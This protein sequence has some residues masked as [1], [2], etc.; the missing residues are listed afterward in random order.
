MASEILNNLRAKYPVY[1][2][3][4]DAELAFRITEKYP[5]YK[6]TDL[7]KDAMPYRAAAFG[8]ISARPSRPAML[9]QETVGA[10]KN[11]FG[12]FDEDES[13]LG[14]VARRASA[15]GTLL[16]MPFRA[17]GQA[18]GTAYEKAVP[19]LPGMSDPREQERQVHALEQSVE[20]APQIASAAR[21]ATALGTK[22][23]QRGAEALTE[24]K[25]KV[26]MTT[27]QAKT[28]LQERPAPVWTEEA[29]APSLPE[30]DPL[31]PGSLLKPVQELPKSTPF[32]PTGEAGKI[33]LGQASF[34]GRTAAGGLLGQEAGDTAIDKI[35][36]GAIG[37]VIGAAANPHLI[38]PALKALRAPAQG[39]GPSEIA[40]AVAKWKAKIGGFTPQDI[41]RGL[42]HAE[43][44]V[45]D[46]FAADDVANMVRKTWNDALDSAFKALKYEPQSSVRVLQSL[47]N[48]T[49]QLNPAEAAVAAEVRRVY[50]QMAQN[51][52]TAIAPK[53]TD[54]FKALRGGQPFR[55]GLE[56]LLG[57][58]RAASKKIAVDGGT[59]PDGTLV[60]SFG[61]RGLKAV[62][63]MKKEG[64]PAEVVAYYTQYLND[65]TKGP[66]VKGQ[67]LLNPLTPQMASRIKAVEFMRTIGLNF[68]SAMSNMLQQ[69]NTFARTSPGAFTSA[70][71]DILRNPGVVDL[72]RKLGVTSEVL[73]KADIDSFA[74]PTA[75]DHMLK[76]G[77][78]RTGFLFAKVEEFNRLH[79]FA[80]GLRD[81]AKQG[82][83]GDAAAKYAQQLVNATQFRFGVE[84]A[85][86]LLRGGNPTMSVLGQYKS[87]QISQTLF[88]KNLVSDAITGKD[89][90]ALWKYL[91]GV[92][93]IA[94]PDAITGH[95]VGDMIRKQISSVFGGDPKDYKFRGVLG[96]LGISL[97][98]QLGLGALPI[99]NV[100]SLAFLLP[101]PA[102][103]H[104]L[105]T[106]SL[107]TN[108]DISVQ[109]ATRGNFAKPL[110]PDQW[111]GL[112]TRFGSVELDKI[113]R[114][115]VQ[116]RSPDQ[117][118]RESRNLGEAVGLRPGTG[119]ASRKIG[120]LEPAQTVLGVK[121]TDV[122]DY[123]TARQEVGQRAARYAELVKKKA[124]AMT[125]ND[126][127]EVKR[128]N[129]I[130]IKEFGR[131]P[132][133][134]E[135]GAK[136]AHQRQNTP[137]L[138]R[139]LRATPKAIRRQLRKEAED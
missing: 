6:D 71:Y 35:R 76:Q 57:D 91:G 109:G 67:G 42:S 114:A 98:Q 65:V 36:Y 38:K 44:M 122:E 119:P 25:P 34:L 111:A 106:A 68:G 115:I 51:S 84:N 127:A 48:P 136:A 90:S 124:E 87:Y 62:A 60:D 61:K 110:T 95:G 112:A 105:D 49:V 11:L 43:S 108:R 100:S 58:V 37:A 3:I 21:G 13:V 139:Q 83:T 17:A 134:K 133:V 132:I 29:H 55:Y 7:L 89:R 8:E 103:S 94:G 82:L 19:Y 59:M 88:L 113:R 78:K 20:W 27:A 123:G 53:L 12:G 66:Q 5:E 22:F 131:M 39:L 26:K 30:Y 101:G 31:P 129:E 24:A 85:P 9:K 15:A 117:M 10:A 80:A 4:P 126:V 138:E 16:G 102:L 33:T 97:G 2:S 46:A 93:A 130:G 86:P 14:D 54:T 63:A 128:L 45:E 1:D 23:V 92:T 118:L 69:M 70:Y 40:K 28:G 32:D 81:A 135:P 73:A 116:L 99:E 50:A 52:G 79:A 125:A 72:A 104:M 64:Y 74:S 56:D 96:E 137:A 121:G 41:A 47:D 77:A 107:V 120:P 18:A 75:F